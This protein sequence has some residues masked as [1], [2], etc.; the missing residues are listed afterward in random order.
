MKRSGTTTKRKDASA[1]PGSPRP[2]A[3]AARK[4]PSGAVEEPPR[5]TGDALA[6]LVPATAKPQAERGFFPGA[7]LDFQKR[8]TA[9]PSFEAS[10][11]C[12]ACS[13]V[14]LR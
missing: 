3:A 9:Q 7:V 10:D 2:G 6:M 13:K 4:K 14:F 1:A 5:S 11:A 8:F 12:F